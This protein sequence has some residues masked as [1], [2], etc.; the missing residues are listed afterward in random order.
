MAP[1]H[2]LPMSQP[3]G[4]P[5]PDDGGRSREIAFSV[6]SPLWAPS[7]EDASTGPLDEYPMKALA[8]TSRGPKGADREDMCMPSHHPSGA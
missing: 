3:R 4:R 5:V 6:T 1:Y 7:S 2:Q 8:R